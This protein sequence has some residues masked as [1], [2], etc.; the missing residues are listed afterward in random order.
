MFYFIVTICFLINANQIVMD[1][2]YG[3]VNFVYL[4]CFGYYI[5]NYYDDTHNTILYIGIYF[6]C[7]FRYIYSKFNYE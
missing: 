6:F 3:I 2:G 4:Y 7:L 1:A 5:R